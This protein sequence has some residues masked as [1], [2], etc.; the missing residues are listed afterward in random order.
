MLPAIIG[1][2]TGHNQAVLDPLHTKLDV[3]EVFALV[4]VVPT[5][6]PRV[7]PVHFG[8]MFLFQLPVHQLSH[9]L[10]DFCTKEFVAA[11]SVDIGVEINQFW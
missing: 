2:T 9:L 1:D 6:L 4:F 11:F 10:L 5:Q 8:G 7:D 3:V